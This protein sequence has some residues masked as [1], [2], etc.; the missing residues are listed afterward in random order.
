MLKPCVLCKGDGFY[1]S[2]LDEGDPEVKRKGLYQKYWVSR[3]DGSSKPG[4][5]HFGCRHFVLDVDH[6]PYAAP[7]LRA[8]AQACKGVYPELAQELSAIASKLEAALPMS[9]L[10]GGRAPE[11]HVRVPNV[12]VKRE[13]YPAELSRGA[14]LLKVKG[15]EVWMPKYVIHDTSE[16]FEVGTEG[17]LVIP[18][19]WAEKKG[20][21]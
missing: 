2:D 1:I 11:D 17:T 4:K 21:V 13:T 10:H 19:E 9:S 7:A 15:R 18:F 20:L 14:L 12:S 3:T 5:K 6:D 8:Y 16:V